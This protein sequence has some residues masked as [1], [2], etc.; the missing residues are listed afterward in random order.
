M[1]PTSGSATLLSR[2]DT[3]VKTLTAQITRPGHPTPSPRLTVPTT[4]LGSEHDKPLPSSSSGTSSTPASRLGSNTPVK[5]EPV[6]TPQ[7]WAEAGLVANSMLN[8]SKLNLGTN[9][10]FVKREVLEEESVLAAGFKRQKLESKDLEVEQL[11]D[12]KDGSYLVKWTGL[13]KEQSTW[14]PAGKLS[15]A[16]LIHQFH[17]SK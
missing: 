9:N 3:S 11:L 15:C 7:V 10:I 16:Q 2:S 14:E 17:T 5:Q 6:D 1:L 4:T 12:Y 13:S 8:S